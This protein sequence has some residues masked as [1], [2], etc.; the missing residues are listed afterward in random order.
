[1]RYVDL[2]C[3]TLTVGKWLEKEEREIP[4]WKREKRQISLR[5]L[6]E[7]ECA[8]QTFALFSRAKEEGAWQNTLSCI[9]EY[10]KAREEILRG[11]V[12]PILSIEDGGSVENDLRRVQYLLQKGVKIF[13]ITWNDEN[14]LGFPCGESGGLKPFGKEVAEYLFEQKVYADLSH[15]SDEGIEELTNMAKSLRFPVIATH[16]LSR[17][18]CPHKRNLTD[19]QIRDIAE[20]G[21]IIG[22]NFAPHFIGKEGLAM[23]I[24]HIENIGGEDVLAIGT[25]FDGIEDP[26]YPSADKMQEFFFDM[27]KAG[28]SSRVIEK[29]AYKNASRLLSLNL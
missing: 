14:C 25:D 6:R 13:G 26:V 8:A 27:Q 19:E 23:H 22:V 15:L 21:G 20:V 29:L 4:F 7:G 3:D 16:S 17:T 1:M 11:G 18:V 12:A 10:E 9:E 2:H 28:F 24:R 5:K